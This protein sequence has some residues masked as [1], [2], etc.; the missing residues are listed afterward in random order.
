MYIYIYIY[1]YTACAF[2][3]FFYVEFGGQADEE[4]IWEGPIS[5]WEKEGGGHRHSNHRDEL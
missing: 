1:I 3:L 4:D 2:A 5:E